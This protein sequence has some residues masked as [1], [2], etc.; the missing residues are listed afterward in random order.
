MTIL[1]IGFIASAGGV[2]KIWAGSGVV[3]YSVLPPNNFCNRSDA[4]EEIC[5]LLPRK[6]CMIWTLVFRVE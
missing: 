5:G 2:T 3:E 4:A 1:K 6:I